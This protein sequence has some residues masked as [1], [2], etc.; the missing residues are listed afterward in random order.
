MIIDSLH[1]AFHMIEIA[2]QSLEKRPWNAQQDPVYAEIS[3]VANWI[4]KDPGNTPPATW[5]EG[6]TNTLDAVHGMNIF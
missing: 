5:I 1:K 6:G 4:F 2:I 3:Q